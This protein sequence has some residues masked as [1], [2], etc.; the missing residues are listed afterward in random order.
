MMELKNLIA[1]GDGAPNVLRNGRIS[2]CI[3]AYSQDLGLVRLYPVPNNKIRRWDIFDAVVEENR[4]DH[5]DNTWKIYNSKDWNN[6]FRCIRKK[7][8][9]PNAKRIELVRKLATDTL[10]GLIGKMKSFGVITPKILKMELVQRNDSTTIQTRLFDPE[11][12]VIEQKDYKFKPYVTYECEGQCS[13]KNQKHKQQIVEWG[14]YEWM[15]KLP[16]DTEH[17]MKV[18]DN[19]RLTDEGWEKYFL[20]GNLHK[21]PKTYVIVAVLRFKKK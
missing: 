9:L 18:F 2:R 13:C 4:Q 14:C 1:L 7:G 19:L 3:C 10:G 6:I 21:A 8:Q 12:Q 20:V 16:N 11:Y 17:C 15:R 5:R